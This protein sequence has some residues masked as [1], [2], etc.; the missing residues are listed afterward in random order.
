MIFSFGVVGSLVPF[1]TRPVYSRAV[2]FSFPCFGLF[3]NLFFID[4]KKK[5]KKNSF[6]KQE[7]NRPLI[8]S[9]DNPGGKN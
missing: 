7:L 5:K 2:L 3:I 9:Y 6:Q 8:I 4:Q 1:C